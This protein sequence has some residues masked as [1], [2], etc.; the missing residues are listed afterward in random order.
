MKV[1]IE[2]EAGSNK[3]N[4]FNEK[5]LTYKNTFEVSRKYPYPYGFIIDTT[6]GDSDNLDCFVLTDR[7][8]KTGD[9]VEVEPVGMFEQVEDDQNDPKI[10]ACLIGEHIVIDESIRSDL[11]EF[12]T[13]VFDHLPN[14]K[15]KIGNFLG[16][17]PAQELIKRFTDK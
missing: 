4:C 3:K 11:R 2:N 7:E 8:L 10:L 14:K 5:T 6:S 9:I 12:I 16:V 15:I 13:H 1:F 17:D